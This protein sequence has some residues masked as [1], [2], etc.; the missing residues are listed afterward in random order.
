M[1]PGTPPE[2]LALLHE[3]IKHA[4]LH[5]EDVYTSTESPETGTRHLTLTHLTGSHCSGYR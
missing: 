1:A 3:P 5:A 2:V 4:Q